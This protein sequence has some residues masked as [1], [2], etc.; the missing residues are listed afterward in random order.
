[1]GSEVG[2]LFVYKCSGVILAVE[3]YKLR[4]QNVGNSERVFGSWLV[5]IKIVVANIGNYP[6]QIK[7]IIFIVFFY[8]LWLIF[9]FY[10]QRL[11]HSTLALSISPEIL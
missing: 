1:M 2:E 5:R 4:V 10:Y 9:S 7:T 6:Q 3:E 11:T 8:H